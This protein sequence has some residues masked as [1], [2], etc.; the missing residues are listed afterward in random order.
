MTSYNFEKMTEIHRTAVIDIFNYFIVN[1]FAA[2]PVEPVDYQFYDHFLNMTKGYPAV[3]INDGTENVVGFAFLHPYR[4]GPA[5]Q[6]TAEITYFILPE[7]TDKG[8][9]TSV[10]KRFKLAAKERGIEILLANISSLNDGSIR[11]HLNNG[12]RECGHFQGIGK[13][14]NRKFDVVWM[15]LEL[16]V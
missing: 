13:K 6:Q 8:L 15:A 1:S 11:F 3:V 14:F 12:F 4:P 10:L 16:N 7:H 9:G 2:Y 5:F